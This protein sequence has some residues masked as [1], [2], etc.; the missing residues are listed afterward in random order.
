MI[1]GNA[2][3]YKNTPAHDEPVSISKGPLLQMSTFGPPIG[4]RALTSSEVDDPN[5]HDSRKEST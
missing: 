1:A 2:L 3:Y 5:I 4:G